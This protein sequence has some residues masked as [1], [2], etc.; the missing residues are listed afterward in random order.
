MEG[1]D[2][3]DGCLEK[4]V[5]VLS[6]FASTGNDLVVEKIFNSTSNLNATDQLVARPI[7]RYPICFKTGAG[8]SIILTT[9]MVIVSSIASWQ[10]I[11]SNMESVLKEM[12][13]T[14]ITTKYI[15]SNI[16]TREPSKTSSSDYFE[17]LRGFEQIKAFEILDEV[18]IN[19]FVYDEGQFYLL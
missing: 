12:T 15:A 10:R 2:L 5:A 14:T 1:A 11:M 3:S 4:K 6:M 18:T 16:Q 17:M 8:Y 13:K 9:T 7:V 19:V